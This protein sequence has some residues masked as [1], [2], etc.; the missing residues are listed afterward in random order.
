[1][2]RVIKTS[3]LVGN[4]ERVDLLISRC[5]GELSTLGSLYMLGQNTHA[6][7]LLSML[8]TPR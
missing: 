6:L 3:F 4:N 8:S 1:M 5:T 7:A 2:R